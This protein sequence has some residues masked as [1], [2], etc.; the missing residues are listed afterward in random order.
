MTE[1]DVQT[2]SKYTRLSVRTIYNLV[3]TG[4]IPYKRISPKKVIFIEEEIDEWLRTREDGRKTK[5]IEVETRPEEASADPCS[6]EGDLRTTALP[7]HFSEAPL[8]SS[9]KA[10]KIFHSGIIAFVLIALGWGG[11]YLYFKSQGRSESTPKP[12]SSLNGVDMETLLTHGKIDSLDF[13]QA[14]ND[15]DH[16]QVKLDYLSQIVSLEGAISSPQ[17]KPFL[18]NA[19]RSE[20]D[21]Y[22]IKS[23]TMDALKTLFLDPDVKGALIH[24]LT[25]D[26]NP[27]I[28]MKAMTVLANIAT[29]DE[30]NKALVDR[31]K[32]DENTGIRFKAL[33]L[34][35]QS[36]GREIVSILRNLKA[37][38]KNSIIKN[39]IDA[40]Y[41]KYNHA[42]LQKQKT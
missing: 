32:N 20:E 26:Q 2:T 33:E 34:I 29:S 15:L 19:L 10:Q 8:L 38:D 22:A 3:S 35:E 1:M 9:R 17:I 36:M 28:R 24:S 12:F 6:F 40:I 13:G 41:R 7:H 30:V 37:P 14:S 21:N 25:H 18:V 5:R 42:P 31:L 39:R 23:K 27:I 16:V 11:G 4:K